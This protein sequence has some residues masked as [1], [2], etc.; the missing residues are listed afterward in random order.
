MARYGRRWAQRFSKTAA[1]IW[2]TAALWDGVRYEPGQDLPAS[3]SAR[4]RMLWDAGR[5][6]LKPIAT[7]AAE[8]ITELAQ[9]AVQAVLPE[10]EA[11]AVEEQPA[12]TPTPAVLVPQDGAQIRGERNQPQHKGKGRR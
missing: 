8:A 7:A 9:A 3:A 10:P 1:M 12:P 4:R 11:A 5:I 2:S 6:E